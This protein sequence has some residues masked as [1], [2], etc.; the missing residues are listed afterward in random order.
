MRLAY[1]FPAAA[2][3]LSWLMPLHLLPWVV[4]HSEVA[5]FAGIFLAA[6]LVLLP[7]ALRRGAPRLAITPAAAAVLALALLAIVQASMGQLRYWGDAWVLLLYAGLCLASY[8]MGMAASQQQAGPARALEVLAVTLVLAGVGSTIIS[9]V[10]ALDVW[11]WSQ[12]IARPNQFRRPGGNYAQPNQMATMLL[13]GLVGLAYLYERHRLS[14]AA[15]Q[16]TAIVLFLGFATAESR[17]GLVSLTIL[18]AFWVLRGHPT[19]LK[20]GDVAAWAVVA[21]ATYVAWPMAVEAFIGSAVEG[22]QRTSVGMRFVVWP[23]LGHALLAQPWF[24]WGLRQTSVALN[25]VVDGYALSEP[26]TYAHNLVLEA[27]LGMGIP[28]GL[29]F[30]G[31]AALWWIRRWR[32]RMTQVGWTCMALCIPFAVHA[33]LEFPYAYAY[34]LAPILFAMGVIDA[35][36]KPARA[37]AVGPR[38]AAAALLGV[39]TIGALS[40]FEYVQIEEDFRVVRFE[41]GRIGSTPGDYERPAVHVLTQLDALLAAGRVTPRPGMNAGEIDFLRDVSTR[42]P[43]P[44]LQNRYAASLALN[45]Q[46]E[47]AERELRRVRVLHGAG[48]FEDTRRYWTRMQQQHPQLADVALPAP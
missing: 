12:W 4:W 19:R 35:Q 15:M 44:A 34:V 48:L 23:Q 10:Q 47:E 9:L 42:F 36:V 30:V 31:A 25:S 27:C 17:A 45:G 2:L 13:M 3:T 16:A 20:R 1:L 39:S 28:L 24:G 7:L 5:V 22:L 8:G 14:R 6:A 21:V 11:D 38:W 43:W 32:M 26:Y 33:M 18:G 46:R 41:S 40:V 29:A 37:V